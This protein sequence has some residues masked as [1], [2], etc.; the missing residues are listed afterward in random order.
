[1]QRQHQ[2]AL[3]LDFVVSSL[4]CTRRSRRARRAGERAVPHREVSR[5]GDTHPR[6]CSRPAPLPLQAV[7]SL[8]MAHAGIG[9]ACAGWKAPRGSARSA[10]SLPP[11][12]CPREAIR[13]QAGSRH[14]R[15]QGRWEGG[16]GEASAT[17]SHAHLLSLLRLPQTRDL[18][19][20]RD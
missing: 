17:E 16:R 12:G 1:M 14:R 13:R 15:Q 7:S 6:G 5:H 3:P 20:P 4:N 2:R 19:P 8:L 18:P 11:S 9:T 10:A